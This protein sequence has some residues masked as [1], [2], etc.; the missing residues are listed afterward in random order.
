L[1]H[2]P[3][4]Y[5]IINRK[6]VVNQRE[7]NTVQKIFAL[8]LEIRSV[9][10]LQERLATD[11][12]TAKR[13]KTQT[14]KLMGGG[15]FTHSTLS[16]LLRNPV[17]LGK[18]RQA[19]ELYEGE[20]EAIID[21][22]LWGDAQRMLEDNV[23]NTR[24]AKNTKAN[25]LLAGLLYDDAGNRMVPSH[26]RKGE[27]V[28]RYY[29]SAP[30][31]RGSKSKVGSVSRVSAPRIE[32]EII[33]A[34]TGAKIAPPGASEAK[35]LRII[36]K[37]ILHPVEIE[38]RLNKEKDGCGFIRVAA[39]LRSA[40]NG[41]RIIEEHGANQRSESLVKAIALA[42]DW[43]QQM[44]RGSFQTIKALADAKG[45]SDSYVWKILRLGY[46]APDI[47]EANLDGRQPSHLSLHQINAAKLSGDWT[48]QR[49][50][51]GFPALT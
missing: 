12:V 49:R 30:L 18:V 33:N 24:T 40:K 7:A 47:I 32:R 34:L 43:R 2:P 21:E 11:G 9:A 39:D 19:G 5:D 17:Y 44:E 15:P 50:A 26:A 3:L 1:G 14:A 41:I 51:L 20:H 25:A 31:M 8:A 46:L 16:R 23:K 10:K 29:T 45:L 13:W 35:L 36:D 4:G 28:Y 38:I 42:H 22:T 6:L 27:T 48:S 37:I